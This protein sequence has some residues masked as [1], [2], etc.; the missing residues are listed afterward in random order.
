LKLSLHPRAASSRKRL[1]IGT[2]LW[3]VLASLWLH[4]SPATA[5]EAEPPR[6]TP[7]PPVPPT[8][9]RLNPTGRDIMLTAPLRDGPFILG[10]VDFVLGADDGL[11]INARRLLDVL[12]PR[13]EPDRAQALEA[14]LGAL[15]YVSAEETAAAG[16]P[17]RYVP[18]TIGLSVDIPADARTRRQIQLARFNDE[19][20]GAVDAPANVAGYV[21]FRTFTDYQWNGPNSGLE[22]PTALIDGAI[23]Y[24][25][26]VLEG[27]ATLRLSGDARTFVREGTRIVYDDRDRLVRW[28]AGDLRPISRGFAGT[29]QM[30]GV[31]VVRLYSVLEPQRNVQPRGDRNFTL[32]R[33]STV[34]AIINGQPIRRIRLDP[35]TYDLRDFPFVQGANDVQIVVEDDAGGREVIEFSTFFD[36][37]L[38]SPGLTE[39]GVF[40]GI[41]SRV[42]NGRRTYETDEPVASGFFRRGMTDNLTLGGNFNASRRGAVIGGEVVAATRIGTIGA[43][44]A[45][46]R[47]DNIGTG[48][49]FNTNLLYTFG[50]SRTL[51]RSVGI[52]VEHRSRNFANPNEL[53]ADNRFAWDLSATYAQAIDTRQFISITGQY[54]IARGAFQNEVTVRANYGFRI[55]PRINFTAEATYEDR[56]TFGEDYGIRVGIL[57]R[58]GPRSSATAEYDSRFGRAR[59][60]YQTSDGDGVGAWA[61][62][63]DVSVGENDIGLDGG[64][65]YYANRAELSVNHASLFDISGRTVDAQRTSLRVG[66]ALV[67]ADGNVTLSRP[68]YDS[69]VMVRSHANLDGATVYVDPREDRYSARS[70]ALGPA[71]EP[72]L[73]AYIERVLSFDVPEAPVGYDLGRGNVRVFP[74][75]RS[76]YLVTAGSDYSVTAVGTL[77]DQNG[78]PVSLLA[79]RAVELAAPEREPVTVFT[80][81]SG[82][83]G[84]AGLR[85]GRWRIDMPTQPA[86]SV[87]I[88]VP[89]TERGVLRLGQVQLGDGQ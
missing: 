75:Y 27:E 48:F 69:F 72:N 77:V 36:R 88:E 78:Q 24:R 62:S 34:E 28:T 37:T 43:D 70:D 38:L 25:N 85:P 51:G 33:P 18:E 9:T 29:T 45:F 80:N 7:Q 8:T 65:T 30:A 49:A 13:L 15:S 58:F 2:S 52:A 55:T 63:A 42:S 10:E 23:R 79:G 81:R 56:A 59:F 17:V 54:S 20:N 66:T 31:S 86:S 21:N 3:L 57:V 60:G 84:I 50:G 71:V 35:G 73:S 6:D 19:L 22:A 47:V 46:S 5:Q 1:R 39:F 74:P 12:M 64:A 40:G 68:I 82:R 32:T 41:R 67:F 11:R 53:F 83:F 89:A 26:F 44:V 16:Y 76:G 14:R 4:A 87:V 61:A